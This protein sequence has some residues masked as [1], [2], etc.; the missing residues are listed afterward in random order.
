MDIFDKV[1]Q[2]PYIIQ[3]TSRSI[4]TS[5]T[6]WKSLE[7]ALKDCNI[8]EKNAS[9][10]SPQNASRFIFTWQFVKTCKN[11]SNHIESLRS[12]QQPK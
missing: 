5:T 4:I 10:P 11:M 8:L 1:Q 2:I 3:L 7:R 6:N 12:C 9:T